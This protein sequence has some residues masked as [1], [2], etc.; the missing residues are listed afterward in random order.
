MLLRHVETDEIS[1]TKME[2]NCIQCKTIILPAVLYGSESWTLSKAHEALLRGFEKN[3]WSSTGS[4]KDV[5]I[6]N[7][8]VYLMML[9]QLRE[10]K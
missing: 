7:Y 4:G 9:I 2:N 1:L 5:T 3:L 8:I 6:R 10:L